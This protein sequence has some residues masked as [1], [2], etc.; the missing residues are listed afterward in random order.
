MPLLLLGQG[1]LLLPPSLLLTL[2]LWALL[3]PLPLLQ[4]PSLLLPSFPLLQLPLLLRLLRCARLALVHEQLQLAQRE[5]VKRRQVEVQLPLGGRGLTL[6][7]RAARHLHARVDANSAHVCCVLACMRACAV[8]VCVF[9][10][11]RR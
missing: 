6:W 2:L 10:C 9:A 3:L 11:V 8:S 5:R 4:H 1:P 7:G